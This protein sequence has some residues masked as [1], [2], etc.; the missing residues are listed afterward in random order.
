M[1]YMV[2]K[3]GFLVWI[4]PSRYQSHEFIYWAHTTGFVSYVHLI[5]WCLFHVRVC[6]LTTQFS[7]HVFYSDL[8]DTRV[9]F[10]AGHLAFITP[11]VGEFLTPLDL[12]VQILEFGPWWTSCWSVRRSGSVVD[13]RKTSQGPYPSRPPCSSLEFS[14]CNSWVYF[15]LIIIVY[16]FYQ[17]C[18]I[19]VILSHLVITL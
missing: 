15:V 8:L 10:S 5:T 4:I 2:Y 16:L 7:T 11:L 17:W 19:H 9:L 6:I 3:W 13:Q 1:R 18:N 12:Y 14:F